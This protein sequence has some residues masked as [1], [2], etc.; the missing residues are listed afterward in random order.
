[1]LLLQKMVRHFPGQIGFVKSAGM[2]VRTRPQ[3]NWRTF[4]NQRL[5]W[6]SKSRV[7]PEWRITAALGGVFV[8]C[9]TIL[10]SFLLAFWQPLIFLPLGLLLLAWKSGID[11]FFLREATHFFGRPELMRHFGIAQIYHILYIAGVGLVANFQKK[12]TWKGRRV[13]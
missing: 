8:F 5:R 12:Y 1:M 6:A 9:W 13:Q 4:L 11:Y 3:P 7:Y 10:L 2:Q